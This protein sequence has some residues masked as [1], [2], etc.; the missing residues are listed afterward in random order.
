MRA[1]APLLAA[2][3]GLA[4]C[5]TL[6]PLPGAPAAGDLVAHAHGALAFAGYDVSAR[7]GEWSDGTAEVAVDATR[8][9]GRAEFT[10]T[11]RGASWAVWFTQFAGNATWQEGGVRA[12]FDER[13][14]TGQGDAQLPKL[15]AVHAGWGWAEVRSNGTLLTDPTTGNATFWAHYVAADPGPRNAT[16]HRLQNGH[17][18][19]YTP[20]R[21]E[22]VA[23]AG[24][25][26]VLLDVA[27]ARALP[28]DGRVAITFTVTEPVVNSTTPLLVEAGDGD[29]AWNFTVVR[30]PMTVP[31]A[32]LD[33]VLRDPQGS[34]LDTWAYDPTVALANASMPRH[35]VRVPAPLAL[36]NYTA[37]TT[38][39]GAGMEYQVIG[40]VRYPD[41]FF[42]HVEYGNTTL[43]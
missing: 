16:S 37:Q 14:S 7:S 9:T 20:G 3:L 32:K 4:G 13:G 36:G 21:P 6:P 25:P 12:G 33:F 30:P 35:M 8:D 43:R 28:Q 11:W 42:V 39:Y 2:L 19:S 24:E 38:G 17:G 31:T 22:D 27:S 1:A 5:A 10:F 15:H 26:Q 40:T 18:G 23:Y 29:M 41:A 34:V